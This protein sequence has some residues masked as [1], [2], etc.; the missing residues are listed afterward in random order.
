M[1]GI[2]SV[3]S[4]ILFEALFQLLMRRPVTI[5]DGSAAVTGLLLAMNLSSAVLI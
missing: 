3:A 1:I 2:V 4:S 5:W